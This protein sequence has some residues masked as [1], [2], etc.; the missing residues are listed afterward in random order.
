MQK[1]LEPVVFEVMAPTVSLEPKRPTRGQ[2]SFQT[3][4]HHV[5]LMMT[6]TDLE[7]LHHE[8]ASRLKAAPLPARKAKTASSSAS[9]SK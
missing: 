6:R 7:F 5:C 2:I 3:E 4:R 9:R 1:R 8:I